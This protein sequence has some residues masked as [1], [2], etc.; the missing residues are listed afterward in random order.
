MADESAQKALSMQEAQHLIDSLKSEKAKAEE[1]VKTIRA[2]LH[3]A[4]RK[5]KA[6]ES[7]RVELEKQIEVLKA[8]QQGDE[9]EQIHHS[10]TNG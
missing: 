3:G 6:S 2:K 5:G 9:S 1:E 10:K 4:V 7:A 8:Q